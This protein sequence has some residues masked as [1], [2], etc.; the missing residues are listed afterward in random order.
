[1]AWGTLVKSVSDETL[2]QIEKPPPIGDFG[3]PLAEPKDRGLPEVLE[4]NAPVGQVLHHAAEEAEGA[5]RREVDL[6]AAGAAGRADQRG[7]AAQPRR[8]AGEAFAIARLAA[9]RDPERLGKAD[10]ERDDEA[11]RLAL[12]IGRRHVLAVDG[13][14]L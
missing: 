8:E 13:D 2:R 5:L 6:Q 14:A 1:M 10:D 12:Q 11:G 3:Q 4:G 9:Q 7:P